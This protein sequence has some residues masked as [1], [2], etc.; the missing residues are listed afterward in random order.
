MSIQDIDTVHDIALLKCLDGHAVDHP[1]KP[2]LAG[3]DSLSVGDAVISLSYPH[4]LLGNT[5]LIANNL[6]SARAY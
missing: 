2:V 3:T 4:S 5:T 1:S 6:L